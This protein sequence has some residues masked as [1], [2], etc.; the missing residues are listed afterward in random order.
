MHKLMESDAKEYQSVQSILGGHKTKVHK[1][2]ENI[3]RNRRRQ[4]I[5]SNELNCIS[6]DKDSNC[7]HCV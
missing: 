7:V 2:I 1:L 6:R 5:I 3:M 4:K